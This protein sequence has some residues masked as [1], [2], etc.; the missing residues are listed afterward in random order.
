MMMKR[1]PLIFD[2]VLSDKATCRSDEWYD[3]A[4]DLRNA[5]IKNGL[6]GTGPVILVL[7]I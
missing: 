2:N 1:C 4:L 6:Y 5:V 3:T 7:K